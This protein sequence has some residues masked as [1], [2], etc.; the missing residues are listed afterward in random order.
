L[1]GRL[2]LNR[3]RVEQGDVAVDR[4]VRRFSRIEFRFEGARAVLA[5]DLPTEVRHPGTEVPVTARAGDLDEG[6][7]L[8]VE[9]GREG[10]RGLVIRGPGKERV[11]A[12]SAA[13]SPTEMLQAGPQ[14][15]AAIRA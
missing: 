10:N 13:D 3:R 8:E 5:T 2:G 12:V 1:P 9:V 6:R 11:L 14:V 4:V 15:A 7:P